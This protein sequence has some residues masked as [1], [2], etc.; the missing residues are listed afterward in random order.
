[1]ED[2]ANEA[3]AYFDA[4]S[5]VSKLSPDSLG[6]RALVR[7]AIGQIEIDKKGGDLDK[8]REILGQA[9]AT[10]NAGLAA[11]QNNP[12]RIFEH[13]QSQYWLGYHAYVMGDLDRLTARWSSYRDLTQ[14][15]Y[16]D[17]PAN[18]EW[19]AC[20]LYTSPSPRDLSTSRMPS[21]A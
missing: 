4:Q 21:S 17:D 2:V 1:M 5:E 14:R 3:L 15:L 13:A 9:N 6:K 16:R 10:T 11:D 12:N 19:V 8:A 18:A 7:H 20:L